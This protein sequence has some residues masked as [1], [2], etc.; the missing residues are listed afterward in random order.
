MAESRIRQ[1]LGDYARTTSVKNLATA[2]METSF[3]GD[4]RAAI[5]E[6]PFLSLYGWSAIAFDDDDLRGVYVLGDPLVLESHLATD[7]Q[8]PAE[9]E[10][11]GVTDAV[12]R[13]FSPLGRLFR[14]S[15]QTA[16]NFSKI[17]PQQRELPLRC[18][19]FCC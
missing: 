12:R 10:T 4:W 3:E 17:K 18:N 15:D 2:A 9:D 1:I 19:R 14:R 16:K 11:A 8:E 6:A 5:E 7:G 13:A